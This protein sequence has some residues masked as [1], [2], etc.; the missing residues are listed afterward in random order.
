[1]AQQERTFV[2]QGK[3]RLFVIDGSFR[4]WYYYLYRRDEHG[5]L[6]EKFACIGRGGVEMPH[7]TKSEWKVIDGFPAG[8]EIIN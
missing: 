1:M 3:Y 4:Q 8:A 5:V 7:S 2:H 6:E